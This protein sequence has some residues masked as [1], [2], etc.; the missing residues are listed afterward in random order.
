MDPVVLL[1]Q[2]L[3]A[4]YKATA[5]GQ[6]DAAA[7]AQQFKSDL[8]EDPILATA[9]RTRLTTLSSIPDG[10]CFISKIHKQFL[11]ENI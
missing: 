7:I 4:Y 1:N 5:M 10:R 8:Q 11:K 2:T 3:T 6:G 9:A